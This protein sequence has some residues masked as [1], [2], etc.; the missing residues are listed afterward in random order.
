MEKRYRRI[1]ALLV[2]ACG[3]IFFLFQEE[4][5]DIGM[6]TLI[7]YSVHE[8]AS[9]IPLLSFA[10]TLVWV[11]CLLIRVGR[12]EA[13]R[14]DKIFFGVLLI[15]TLTQRDYI[16]KQETYT[17]AVVTIESIDDRNGTILTENSDGEQ[18][19]LEAPMIVRGVL[20]TDGQEYLISYT[21]YWKEPDVGKLCTIERVEVPAQ[22]D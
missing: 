10:V 3:W 8:L 22:T 15:L 2:G 11:I 16:W 6:Y 17:T 7:P 14:A 5:A 4:M 20:E 12:R 19:E 18:M 9:V 21:W 1:I 13:D